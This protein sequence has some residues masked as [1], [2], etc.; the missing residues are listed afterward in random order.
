MDK[1]ALRILL[2]DSDELFYHSI[3]DMLSG[4]KSSEYD[5]EWSPTCVDALEAIDRNE[6]DVCLLDYRL[7]DGNALGIFYEVLGSDSM[8]PV[9]LLV[10]DD[11]DLEALNAEQMNYLLKDQLTPSSLS[12]S[13]R[14]AIR[15]K[16]VEKKLRA[17]HEY[18]ENL[19]NCSIDMIIAVDTSRKIMEFNPAAE[20]IFG[21]SKEEILGKDIDILYDKPTQGLIMNKKVGRDGAF[22]GEVINRKKN[23]ETFVAY[24]SASK[25]KDAAGNEIGTMGIS[26]DIT[27]RKRLEEQLRHNAFHDALTALP[28]RNLFYE[29]LMHS[30]E[31]TKRNRKYLYAVLFLDV[32]RFKVIN[33]SLGHAAGD[34]LLVSIAK[35][36]KS[37]LRATDIIA[38]FG[39]DEF[40]ILLDD[41][42]KPD[43]ATDVADRLLRSLNPPF[44]LSGQKLSTS[45]SIGIVLGDDTYAKPEDLLRDADTVM[46]M[47]KSM[48]R[49]RY[50]IFDSRMHSQMVRVM[51]LEADM[52]NAIEEEEFTLYFQPI[53]SLKDGRMCGVETLIRWEDPQR[54]MVPPDEFIPLAEE[55]GLIEPIGTWVLQQACLQGR[56]WQD[57]GHTELSVSVNFS[58]RQFQ[59]PFLPELIE[60]TLEE[61][62]MAASNLKIEITETMTM[63][64]T[65]Y[66]KKVLDRLYSM[67]LEIL[68][69]DFG[70]GYS[71]INYLQ[72]FPVDT[73]KIDRSLINNIAESPDAAS[74]TN[75]IITMAHSLGK[76]V[77]AEGVENEAQLEI[78]RLQGCDKIQGYLFCRPV[79]AAEITKL[80][81]EGRSLGSLGGVKKSSA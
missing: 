74:I 63:K 60:Q 59:S 36:L 51:H 66:S 53:V 33:D 24:L 81:G 56:A 54:G 9:I 64:D 73:I 70:T 3:K 80:L 58:A 32:D 17:A 19:I 11:R 52:R 4:A 20:K 25:L 47:A 57:L 5:L 18:A 29:R 55:T 28:N 72:R 12:H 8:I 78:L 77:I 68:M 43:S 38:R 31:L 35:R 22:S 27:E 67:G 37:C 13:I 14:H 71:A 49:S 62:G 26:R 65:D 48:G 44:E 7:E 23:G 30:I 10:R 79:P 50:A 2:V 46:Y 76:K 21:Y 34:K 40:T 6:H 1:A 15:H 69:D 61:T 41:I 39:G 16:N 45:V 75:A 42:E